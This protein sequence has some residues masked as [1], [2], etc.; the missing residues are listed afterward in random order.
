MQT[1][2]ASRS[3]EL[4]P[5]EAF[6]MLVAIGVLIVL[7]IPSIHRAKESARRSSCMSN[8]RQLGLACK[9]YAV[10]CKDSFP[11]ASNAV[12]L[13]GFCMLTGSYLSAGKV[14][15]CPSDLRARAGSTF[16]ICTNSYCYVTASVDG[17]IPLTESCSSSQPLILDRG[18]EGTPNP[19]VESRTNSLFSV[20]GT[21]PHRGE[22]GNVYF[23]GGHVKWVPGLY[24]EISDGTNGFILRPQ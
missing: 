13:S 10:D 19:S 18:Y 24:P 3:Q 16:A 6:V 22:G 14:Y 23:V 5:A 1:S 2:S 9:Q 21:N 11:P 17:K 20:S 7:I 12:A 15:N 8:T 4:T